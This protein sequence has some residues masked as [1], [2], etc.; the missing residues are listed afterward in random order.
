MSF[1]LKRRIG[2]AFT[3][4]KDF[5][6][7]FARTKRD[8]GLETDLGREKTAIEEPAQ[9]WTDAMDALFCCDL[10]CNR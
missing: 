5:G 2:P 10:L 9:T 8:D 4:L 1:R 6:F 3:K 7:W